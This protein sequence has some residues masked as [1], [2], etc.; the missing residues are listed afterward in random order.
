M[1]LSDIFF[2]FFPKPCFG[3]LFVW[4]LPWRCLF[5]FFSTYIF[6]FYS[7]RTVTE[8]YIYIYFNL[9]CIDIKKLFLLQLLLQW[10]WPV[11]FLLLPEM[12]EQSSS[13]YDPGRPPCVC[14]IS[15]TLQIKSINYHCQKSGCPSFL[16]SC[17]IL[18]LFLPLEITRKLFPVLYAFYC[19]R[20]SQSDWVFL[21]KP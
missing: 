15:F 11:H 14:N 10:W 5:F 7:H 2:F 12:R 19:I 16:P 4:R 13:L 21:S 20:F 6:S 18:H 3:D 9:P 8:R 1:N 17:S